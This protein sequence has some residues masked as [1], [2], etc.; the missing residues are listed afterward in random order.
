MFDKEH[1]VLLQ[2][3]LLNHNKQN[4][5]SNNEEASFRINEDSFSEEH[6]SNQ[7]T[8]EE[9]I[10][11]GLNSNFMKNLLSQKEKKQ[12][13]SDNIKINNLKGNTEIENDIFIKDIFANDKYVKEIN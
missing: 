2:D 4:L 10:M 5:E 12:K 9:N 8:L 6:S 7:E 3:L 11:K 13:K 1:Q